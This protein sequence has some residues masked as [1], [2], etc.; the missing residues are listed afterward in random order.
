MYL[1]C[2]F[3]NHKDLIQ[4]I[5][6]LLI[7]KN[8]CFISIIINNIFL[9]NLSY[10]LYCNSAALCLKYYPKDCICDIDTWHHP[11]VHHNPDT[12]ELI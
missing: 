2:V 1:K 12:L 4:S 8:I 11:T 10:Y 5:I 7:K 6:S 3:T 9:C